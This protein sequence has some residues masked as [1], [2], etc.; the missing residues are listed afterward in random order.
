MSYVTIL[1]RN[2]NVVSLSK[3]SFLCLGQHA[4]FRLEA[5]TQELSG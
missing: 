2:T 4:C 1:T 3:F 5:M